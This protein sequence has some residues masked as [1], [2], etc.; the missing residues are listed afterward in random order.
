VNAAWSSSALG[1]GSAGAA[2]KQLVE[3]DKV[4]I[5][6]SVK[7]IV[8]D[9]PTTALTEAESDRLLEQIRRF[10]EEGVAMLYV[11]HQL[12][13]M[14][15]IGDWVTVL[16]DGGLSQAARFRITTRTH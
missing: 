14:F 2:T 15:A 11:T 5:A 13:E 16:R 7:V 1:V 9:E 4:L 10:R 6:D 8:F 3:I 12:E